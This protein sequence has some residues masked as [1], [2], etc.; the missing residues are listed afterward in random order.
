MIGYL[1]DLNRT[2]TEQCQK[3]T[4]GCSVNHAGGGN[5]EC[6]AYECS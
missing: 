6:E 1:Y 3:G 4:R 2:E 5:Y